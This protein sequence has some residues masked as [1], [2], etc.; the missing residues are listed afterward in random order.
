MLLDVH[1]GERR[2]IPEKADP[3]DDR[4]EFQQGFSWSP[5]ARLLAVYA[6]KVDDTSDRELIEIWDTS[7]LVLVREIPLVGLQD[8][9][10]TVVQGVEDSFLF[11][12]PSHVARSPDGKVLA[13]DSGRT[14]LSL[15]N[16]R[17]GK[18]LRQLRRGNKLFSWSRDGET[19]RTWTSDEIRFINRTDGQTTGVTK[20]DDP[21]PGRT[22]VSLDGRYLAAIR[23]DSN[24]PEIDLWRRGRKKPSIQIPWTR[25]VELSGDGSPWL[26]SS[27]MRIGFPSSSAV[28]PNGRQLALIVDG[29]IQIRDIESG[30]IQFALQQRLNDRV[31]WSPS[32]DVVVQGS[33][34]V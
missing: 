6:D 28:S 14:G 27:N 8:F 1:S 2:K 16:P 23:D 19:L 30:R 33:Y 18:F 24:R 10:Y 25:T 22:A 11:A 15:W 17:S 20:I 21:L 3:K 32:G 12:S 29:A 5:D 7:R 26:S 13:V 34:G 4:S 31:M 9:G